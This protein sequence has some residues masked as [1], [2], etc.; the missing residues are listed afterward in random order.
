MGWEGVRQDQVTSLLLG[1]SSVSVGLS[2]SA[3]L[4]VWPEPFEAGELPPSEPS[5]AGG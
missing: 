2:L 5:L 3:L 1:G 4:L